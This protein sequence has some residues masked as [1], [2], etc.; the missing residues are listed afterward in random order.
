[1]RIIADMGFEGALD[2]FTKHC[3]Y[4]PKRPGNHVSWWTLDEVMD[5]LRRA[6]SRTVYR[7]G[8]RQ[9]VSP[10][11]QGSELFDSTHPQMSV[12]VEAIKAG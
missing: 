2:F 1:M 4:R 3:Q 7:S 10:L 11:M 9:S 6:G 12:Y 8:C 5:F